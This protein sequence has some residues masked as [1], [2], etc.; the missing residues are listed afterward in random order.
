MATSSLVRYALPFVF[1]SLSVEGMVDNR[2]SSRSASFEGTVSGY[3]AKMWSKSSLDMRSKAYWLMA[4]YSGLCA[5]L[6]GSLLITGSASF[7]GES[8]EVLR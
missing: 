6:L 7:G 1:L 8:L 3:C 4:E 2:C 5:S